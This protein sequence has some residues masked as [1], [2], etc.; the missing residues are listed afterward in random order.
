MP[1]CVWNLAVYERARRAQRLQTADVTRGDRHTPLE[2][3]IARVHK[4]AVAGHNIVVGVAAQWRDTVARD[5]M[6]HDWHDQRPT[7]TASP[8]RSAGTR[9]SSG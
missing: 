5:Q 7:R 9:S 1:E 8:R 6:V 2:P 4:Q 3:P